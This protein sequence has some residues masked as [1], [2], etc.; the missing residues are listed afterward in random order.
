[1]DHAQISEYVVR[2]FDQ[3][4]WTAPI[5]KFWDDHCGIF[6]DVEEN[7]LEY[8]A[9]HNR[10]KNLVD[11]LLSAHL[12]ECNISEEDFAQFCQLGLSEGNVFHRELVEQLLALD[13][14][15]VFKA[16]M[17]KRNAELSGEAL[18]LSSPN[19]E[20]FAEL[21][22]LLDE[23]GNAWEGQP[24]Y[25]EA[26]AMQLEAE[27]LELQQRY[28][29][30]ELQLAVAMSQRMQMRLEVLEALTEVLETLTKMNEAEV[31]LAAEAAE[32]ECAMQPAMAAAAA[33]LPEAVYVAPFEYQADDEIGRLDAHEMWVAEQYR[34]RAGRAVA[35]SRGS[36]QQQQ[37][38]QQQHDLQLPYYPEHQSAWGSAPVTQPD[39]EPEPQQAVQQPTAEQKE[40]RAEKLRRQRDLLVAKK[41]R[42]RQAEIAQFEQLNGPSAAA[43]AAEAACARAPA[44]IQD[45]RGQPDGRELAR[46][47]SGDVAAEE[48]AAAES[49]QPSQEDKA[50]EMRRMLTRQL[51]QTLCGT[52]SGGS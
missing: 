29:E 45:L 31:A 22:P 34:E 28:M 16:M 39:D 15:L 2:I 9:I 11:G 50:V 8:T 32:A 7:K 19:P 33:A 1:M 23:A 46:V 10:F 42:D 43:R 17:V 41:N 21:Q 27:R 6:E 26:E 3:P 5:T 4:T 44:S 25:D 51:K 18:K 37:Y 30:A 48:A 47:L 49:A 35:S 20:G 38:L 24:L 14:F 52:M 36:R 40:A 12:A 13:D